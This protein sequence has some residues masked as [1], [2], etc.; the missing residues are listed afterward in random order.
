MLKNMT[1][2]FSRSTD[3]QKDTA[4]Q[5]Q[6]FQESLDDSKDLMR[7]CVRGSELVLAHDLSG[8]GLDLTRLLP[9]NSN[10]E[11]RRLLKDEAGFASVLAKLVNVS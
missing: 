4:K 6:E 9:A 10:R 2:F 1:G 5:L 8:R 3:R 7:E 11:L